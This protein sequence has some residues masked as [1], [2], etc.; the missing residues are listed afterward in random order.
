MI[1]VCKYCGSNNLAVET[2]QVYDPLFPKEYHRLKCC[3]CGK[4][5][6]KDYEEK[7]E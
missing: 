4:I 6:S 3:N 2:A 7:E 5:I 1:D